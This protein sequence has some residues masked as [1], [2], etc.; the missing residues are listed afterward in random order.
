M[1]RRQFIKSAAA[2]ATVPLLPAGLT[3]SSA[4]YAKAVTAA[5]QYTYLSPA[6]LGYVL[7]TDASTTQSVITQLKLDGVLGETAA[8]G[9][10]QSNRFISMQTRLLAK[11]VASGTEHKAAQPQELAKKARDLLLKADENS[12]IEAPEE[13]EVSDET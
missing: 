11:A 7:G 12:E 1:E 8:N 3:F 5:T 6:T 4:N 2:A 13:P 10:I 9:M